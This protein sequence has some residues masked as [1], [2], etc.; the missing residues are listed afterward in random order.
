MEYT[1]KVDKEGTVRYYKLDTGV[2]H[3]EGGPAVE[4]T[5]GSKLW[6]KEGECHREDGPAKEYCDGG[7]YWFLEGKRHREDGPAI[8]CFD[9]CKEWYIEGKRLSEEEFKNRTNEAKVPADTTQ[10]RIQFE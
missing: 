8:E 10:I 9:G 1:V 5:D 2:L 7:K 4:Y 6:F 3:R